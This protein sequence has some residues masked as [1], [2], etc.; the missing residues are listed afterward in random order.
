[1]EQIEIINNNC[2]DLLEMFSENLNSDSSIVQKYEKNPPK[3]NASYNDL[4]DD[5]HGNILFSKTLIG[6]INEIIQKLEKIKDYASQRIKL[7]TTIG[8]IVN[9]SFGKK[10][11]SLQSYSEESVRKN[12]DISQLPE[13]QQK[14]AENLLELQSHREKKGGKSKK[15]M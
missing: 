15:N 14:F 2:D 4:F 8:F 10:V 1:M 7:D 13:E 9:K 6:E 11:P 5:L 12:V 3:D